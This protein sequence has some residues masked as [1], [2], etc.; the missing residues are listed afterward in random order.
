MWAFQSNFDLDTLE[1]Q[2]RVGEND[3]MNNP[4]VWTQRKGNG[5]GRRMS[6]A[7][8]VL[9]DIEHGS[10]IIGWFLSAG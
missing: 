1:I 3:L 10:G 7:I 6:E 2:G 4:C 8:D 5:K 9:E